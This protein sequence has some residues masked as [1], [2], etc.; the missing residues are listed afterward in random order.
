MSRAAASRSSRASSGTSVEDRIL[1]AGLRC[2]GRWGVA[3]TSLDDVA[4]EAGCSRATIYRIFPGGKDSL[5]NRVATRE[6]GHFFA[7]VGDRLSRAADV[8]ALLVAGVT[9]ASRRIRE[10]PA[11]QFLVAHE[12]GALIPRP[13]TPRMA[14]V[15]EVASAF[16]SSHL[17][18][19]LPPATARRAAELVVRLVLSYLSFPS[20]TVDPSDEAGARALV[21]AFVLPVIGVPP[22][23]A[24]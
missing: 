23:A 2:V 14:G 19:H 24:G 6:V 5:F 3:K 10:H 12:P 8:E 16:A 7:A 11:L 13:G 15:I 21:R 4:R 18:R 22:R 1:D 20:G 9:D 17:E